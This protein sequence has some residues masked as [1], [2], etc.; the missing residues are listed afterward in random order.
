M[1][2]LKLNK[3]QTQKLFLSLI[4]FIGLIYVYF[5][6]FLGPLQRSRD[7]ALKSIEDTHEKIASSKSEMSKATRLED[8]AKT[9]TTQF[10]ALRA[11]SPEGAPIAWFPPRIKSFF[12]NQHIDKVTARME[13][14]SQPKEKEL[15]TWSTYNWVIQM[16]QADYSTL[17]KTVAALENSE[18]L[19][20]VMKV[21]IHAA[22]E[23][24]EFQ[25]V[26]LTAAMLLEKR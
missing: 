10:A 7:N 19:L 17:G 20:S 4:G 15:A 26:T 14:S 1:K 22:V 25:Q 5:T 16:P 13:T 2:F 18:P 11:L 21:S 8:Q 23:D 3:D 24:P 12:A 6:F 9:A